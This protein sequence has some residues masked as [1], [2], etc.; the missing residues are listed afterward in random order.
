MKQAVTIDKRSAAR[1]VDTGHIGHIGTQ[2]QQPDTA[3][4]TKQAREASKRKQSNK[5][6]QTTA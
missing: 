2:Q 1:A 6:Q 4:K 5:Q 3:T